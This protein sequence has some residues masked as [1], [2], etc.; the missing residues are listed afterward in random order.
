VPSRPLLVVAAF[1]PEL[2][3]LPARPP[4][5]LTAAV[6][7]GL[8]EAAAGTTRALVQHRPAAVILVGTA[9]VYPGVEDVALAIGR[10]AVV[11]RVRL[12]SFSVAKGWAYLPR[13]VVTSLDTSPELREALAAGAPLADVAC[14]VGITQSLEA[15]AALAQ[16]TGAALEN[17]EAFAVARVCAQAQVPFAAVLGITNVVGPSAH[18]QWAANGDA[19]AAAACALVAAASARL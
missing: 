17:L 7:I 8:V 1:P 2:A 9:G 16:A 5:L 14:P 4:D 19:A 15:G 3:A 12:A 18:A 10:V 13:S 11:R 6:G